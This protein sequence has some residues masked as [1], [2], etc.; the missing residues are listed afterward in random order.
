MKMGKNMAL[1]A[2][3]ATAVLAYQKYNKPVMKK[4]DKVVNNVK[5][6]AND[7]LGNMM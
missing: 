3:G 7:K 1:M 4:V 2:L 6:K 5:E